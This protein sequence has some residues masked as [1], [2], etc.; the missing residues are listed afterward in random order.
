MTISLQP[1]PYAPNALEPFIS[2]KTMSFHYG[3]HHATYVKNTNDL[4]RGTDLEN[5]SLETIIFESASDTVYTALFNN[6]AQAFNHT[7]FWNSLTDQP[8]KKEI[9][10]RLLEMIQ[11]DFG[12]LEQFKAEFQKKAVAQFGSGWAWLVFEEGHLKIITTG[13]A[14][15][16]LVHP[17]QKPLLCIDVWEHAYYLDYQN[18]RLNFVQAILEHLINWDF[19]LKNLE[20]EEK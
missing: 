5:A 4:V 17:T 6:A 14:N 13:N 8:S 16:P 2:E 1:L 15:T 9:P 20:K 19:A 7:F 3:K 12:S 18:A 11:A 10:N